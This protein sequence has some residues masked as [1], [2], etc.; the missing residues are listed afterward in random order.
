MN[1]ATIA[2]SV[3]LGQ[4]QQKLNTVANNLA[5]AN[6]TGF[7]RRETIFTDLLVQQVNHLPLREETGRVT[8]EQIRVGHGAAVAETTLQTEQGAIQV[9][10]R[11]LDLALTR[12]GY[13]F[14][15]E[16]DEGIQYTRDGTFYVTPSA[17][18]GMLDLVASDGAP[19]LGVDGPFQIPANY[20]EIVFAEN[21]EMSARLHNGDTIALGQLEL[22]NVQRPQL[23][24]A[25]GANRFIAPNPNSGIALTDVLQV[26]TDD[27]VV[28]QY[29]LEAA[30]VNIGHEMTQL[31]EMQRHYEL[32][33]RSISI[34]DE[35]MGL[36]NRLR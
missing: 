10:D 35:M 26:A 13:F 33:A 20:R 29:A 21:G 1:R 18:E 6:T 19:V 17:T 25:V 23:L 32:N 7:K 4:L 34:A 5:N 24:Q 30:N 22:V 27:E 14:Q 16:T 11:M 3:T 8:P 36:V 2:A 12:P 9:T 28:Q 15:I 31:I